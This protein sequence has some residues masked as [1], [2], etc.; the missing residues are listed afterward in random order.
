MATNGILLAK[1]KKQTLLALAEEVQCEAKAITDFCNANG[2]SSPSL[3]Q[4]WPDDLPEHIQASRMKLREAANAVH[5][6]AVGPFDH[7]FSLA[8]SIPEAVPLGGGIPYSEVASKCGVN[9]SHLRRVLRFCMVNRL[10]Q[11]PQPDHVAHSVF[12]AYLVTNKVLLGQLEFLCEDSFQFSTKLVEAHKKWPD[13]KGPNHAAFNVTRETELPRYAYLYQPGNE[14]QAKRFGNML[15]FARLERAT[16]VRFV[17]PAYKWEDVDTLV[18]VGGGTGDVAVTLAK[19]F[20]RLRITVEDQAQSIAT[21]KSTLPAELQDRIQLVE[22]DFFEPR[23][24]EPDLISKTK[25][26][27]LRMILHNWPDKDVARIIQPLLPSVRAGARLLIMEMMVPR[28]GTVPE[29]MEWW[30][31]SLD[32]E[33]MIQFNSRVR[34]KEDWQELF[35]GISPGLVMKSTTTPHGSGLTVMEFGFEN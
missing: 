18:D 6:I 16:D 11:E 14:Q 33:M 12:S 8:W 19:A 30:M 23:M 28:P 10:F 29:T 24:V 20:P 9:I 4:D 27:F 35:E 26:Y 7:L 13:S 32:M 25:T 31:R 5:D 34:S 3:F 17:P 15:E 1:G 2:S 21:G 22:R